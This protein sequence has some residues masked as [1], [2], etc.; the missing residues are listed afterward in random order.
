MKD[1]RSVNG[2]PIESD[3]LHFDDFNSSISAISVLSIDWRKNIAHS[4]QQSMKVIRSDSSHFFPSSDILI[5]L[6]H[7]L[8]PFAF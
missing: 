6:L 8:I 4:A 3:F 2:W 1:Q 7:V 5:S